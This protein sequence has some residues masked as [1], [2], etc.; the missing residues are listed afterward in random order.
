MASKRAKLKGTKRKAGIARQNQLSAARRE[1]ART[2]DKGPLREL[3]QRMA[4]ERR[5]KGPLARRTAAADNDD[6]EGGTP[7]AGTNDDSEGGTPAGTEE[8]ENH[9]G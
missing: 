2:G 8:G 6:P 9:G 3:R 5:A 1:A 7:P 4:E